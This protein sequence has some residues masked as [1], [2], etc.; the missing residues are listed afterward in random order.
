MGLVVKQA[1]GFTEPVTAMVPQ[2]S[3]SIRGSF[4]PA[5]RVQDA[6]GQFTWAISR[7][8]PKTLRSRDHDPIL[9]RSYLGS[10]TAGKWQGWVAVASQP[11]P[12]LTW[13]FKSP[14]GAGRAL[15]C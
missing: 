7:D 6:A 12:Q 2:L 13:A 15:G 5:L 3:L 1:P 10:H 4:L 11:Y 9:Q 14:W 8:P